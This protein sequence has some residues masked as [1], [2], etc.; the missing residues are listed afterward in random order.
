M[1]PVFSNSWLPSPLVVYT[2]ASY[3]TTGSGVGVGE[4]VG[5]GV[6][7]T[8]LSLGLQ[9]VRMSENATR[10]V[11]V[12]ISS[13]MYAQRYQSFPKFSAL[14]IIDILFIADS[15]DLLRTFPVFAGK[16]ITLHS[17]SEK[18]RFI[19]YENGIH[20]KSACEDIEGDR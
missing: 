4:G 5:A 14:A 12:L 20:C 7:S 3:V 6:G 1:R 2:H 19:V 9:E 10:S 17:R 15:F 8:G 13:I 11:N 18:V 16:F